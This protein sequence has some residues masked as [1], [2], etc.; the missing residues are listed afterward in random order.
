MCGGTV[1]IVWRDKS[2]VTDLTKIPGHYMQVYRDYWWMT[3][4]LGQVA[5]WEDRGR[6][7]PQCNPQ[8][9]LATFL[10]EKRGSSTAVQIPLAF[11]PIDPGDY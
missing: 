2:E 6:L 8:K 1:S 10:S 5:F 3:N 9:D 7:H 11:I 4:E